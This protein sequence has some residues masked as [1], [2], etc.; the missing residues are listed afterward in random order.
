MLLIRSLASL[1]LIA[2]VV[3]FPSSV[4]ADYQQAFSNYSAQYSQYRTV[5]SQFTVAR[6]A[7]QT[8][9]TL[10]AQNTA[11]TSFRKVLQTRNAL[12]SAYYDLLQEKLNT[13]PS[14]DPLDIS[15]FGEINNNTKLW[16]K[17][18]NDKIAGSASIED[19]NS[20]SSEFAQ[21]YPQ[22][23]IDSK[24]TIGRV[25]LA[26]GT[27]LDNRLSYVTLEVKNFLT[28]LAQDNDVTILERGILQAQTKHDLYT[29]KH[30]QER[31]YFFPTDTYRLDNL[32]LLQGQQ[33]AIAANQ[34]LSESANYLLELIK[35]VTD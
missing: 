17:E 22:M 29:Q 24:Q 11:I 4:R 1:V 33:I 16:L 6:S 31:Q 2:L 21:R 30:D 32:D 34:Y 7:Y 20:V 10:A 3:L 25:L 28:V 26:Q 9:R 15:A 8:Y 13:T 27:Y 18:N 5:Y 19:L 14:V 35:N 12:V 23:L